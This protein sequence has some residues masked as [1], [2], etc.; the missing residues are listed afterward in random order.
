MLL[1][2]SGRPLE[3]LV[4]EGQPDGDT[5]A[6]FQG[7]AQIVPFLFRPAY[8]PVA[9]DWEIERL[10]EILDSPRAQVTFPDCLY[11]W[12]TGLYLS[13]SNS[14]RLACVDEPEGES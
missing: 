12:S 5:S 7:A 8:D 10:C 14:G 1:D 6:L 3:I 11:V 13:R 9:T 4:L 2:E